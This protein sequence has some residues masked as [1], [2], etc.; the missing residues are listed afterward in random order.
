MRRAVTLPLGIDLGTTRVRIVSTAI[1]GR[2][3]RIEAAASCPITEGCSLASAVTQAWRRLE[4]S[5]RRCVTAAGMPHAELQGSTLNNVSGTIEPARLD[6]IVQTVDAAR[7]RL[8]AID[9]ESLALARAVPRYDAVVDIAHSRTSVHRLTETVPQS[10]LIASGG[11]DITLQIERDLALDT[12]TAE[13]RKHRYGSCGGG[14][15]ARDA[16]LQRLTGV[17]QLIHFESARARIALVGS[18]ALLIGL[19]DALR[20]LTG[21]DI[22]MPNS[23]LLSGYC[24]GNGA[25]LRGTEWNLAAGLSTWAAAA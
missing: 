17:L 13:K 19:A 3:L 9:H 25:P 4:T 11:R 16:L 20:M 12:Q 2:K 22:A 7:L 8:L 14:E 1:K 5:E 24:D 15:A 23:S 6:T 10:W 21:F 18:G